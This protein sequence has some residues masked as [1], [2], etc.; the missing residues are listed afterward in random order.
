VFV[1]Y[2]AMY[3]IRNHF[4]TAAPL[5]KEQLGFTTTQLGDIGIVFSI[6]YGLGKTLLGYFVDG[7]DT[8]RIVSVLLMLSALCVAAMGMLMV[9]SGVYMGG[10]MVAWGLSGFFQSVGGPLSYATI[11]KWTPRSKRGRW[12]GFWNASHNIGGA[13]AGLIALWGAS[14]FFGGS[15]IALIIF[16]CS[17]AAALA[18][19]TYFLGKD[20]PESYGMDRSETIWEEPIEKDNLSAESMTKWEVFKTYVLPN[21]YIWLLCV[22]NVFVYI[23][24]IGIDNWAP[25][26]TSEV[27]G[28]SSMDATKTIFWF[29]MGALIGSLTLGW[30]SDLA[31]GRRAL[32][33]AVCMVAIAFAVQFYERGTTPA[34]VFTALFAL[35]ALVFGPQLLIGIAL[36]GFAPKK[37]TAVANG[38]SGTFGYMFGD[39][40]A[41]GLL[42]RIADPKQSGV[43]ILGYNLH[44]WGDTFTVF[45]V[46]LAIGTVVLLAVAFGEEKRIRELRSNDAAAVAASPA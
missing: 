36:T 25:L 46:A 20:S 37:A 9:Y 14:T 17:I 1:A 12:L 3:F 24:R 45:Y 4:K 5:L 28:F 10:I 26:Y 13:L 32:T 29:E 33:A 44:G 18:V 22:A 27:L 19:I 16:P 6:T 23:V 7:R 8:K 2:M 31:G 21:R 11:T 38:M 39:S 40:L 15:V 30:V 42:A 43:T 41:K 35:G 34:M